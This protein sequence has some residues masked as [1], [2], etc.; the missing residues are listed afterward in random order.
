MTTQPTEPT[1]TFYPGNLSKEV[2][3]ISKDGV[4]VNPE[5]TV[6]EAT[7][8]VL[9]AMTAHIQRA[10][11]DAIVAEREACAKLCEESVESDWHNQDNIDTAYECA[12]AIRARGHA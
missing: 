12:A 7:Q 11:N 5:F 4:K 3:R 2:L 8:H 10:V 1:L 9:N 6:D